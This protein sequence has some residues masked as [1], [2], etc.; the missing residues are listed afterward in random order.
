MAFALALKVAA[1]DRDRAIGWLYLPTVAI[2]LSA[3]LGHTEPYSA[4]W[5]DW[6]FAMARVLLLPAT[7]NWQALRHVY[8]VFKTRRAADDIIWKRVLCWQ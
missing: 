8:H 3:M 6:Y 1:N 4:W 5:L 7:V 2:H